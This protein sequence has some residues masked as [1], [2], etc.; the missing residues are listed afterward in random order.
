MRH[1]SPIQVVLEGTIPGKKGRGQPRTNFISQTCGEL[2]LK[3]LNIKKK[4]E[5]RV[6]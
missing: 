3:Y 1:D 5:N 6:K 4:I 2:G